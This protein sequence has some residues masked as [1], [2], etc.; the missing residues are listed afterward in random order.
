MSEGAGGR[1]RGVYRYVVI[2][3]E[4]LTKAWELNMGGGT[5]DRLGILVKLNFF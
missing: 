1:R 5:G 2:S 3:N 4:T